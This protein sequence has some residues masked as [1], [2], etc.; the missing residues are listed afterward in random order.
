[1]ND[2]KP[3]ARRD[4]PDGTERS[5]ETDRNYNRLIISKLV[6]SLTAAGSSGWSF[7]TGD[8]NLNNL[9]FRTRCFYNSYPSAPVC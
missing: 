4:V 1:M 6:D 7:E 3:F 2:T 8:N 9:G 5:G